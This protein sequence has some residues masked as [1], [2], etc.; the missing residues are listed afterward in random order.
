MT[1]TY[2]VSG[3]TCQGCAA[4][5]KKSLAA[6][7]NVDRVEVDLA[8]GVA[9]IVMTRHVGLAQLQDSLG[10]H[11]YQISERGNHRPHANNPSHPVNPANPVNPDPFW[12]S[13]NIW[14]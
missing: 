12:L 10:G 14:R 2:S 13:G 9:E 5:V 8:S 1:H 6:V 7:S 11:A 3:M 4:T